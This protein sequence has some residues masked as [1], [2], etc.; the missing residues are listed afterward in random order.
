MFLLSGQ[1]SPTPLCC[2][3]VHQL[4]SITPCCRAQCSLWFTHALLWPWTCIAPLRQK[5]PVIAYGLRVS[6]QSDQHCEDHPGQ[7]TQPGTALIPCQGVPRS[8]SCHLVLFHANPGGL[9]GGA[10]QFLSVQRRV[11][12][13]FLLTERS[14]FYPRSGKL[15]RAPAAA[16]PRV[17]VIAW[18]VAGCNIISRVVDGEVAD[19]FWALKGRFSDGSPDLL[20]VSTDGLSM[21]IKHTKYC[22]YN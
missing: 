10:E 17:S 14:Y 5:A 4:C 22:K 6:S 13:A 3:C 16:L 2:W 9:A 11:N 21:W 1:R 12:P 18:A 15:G 7:K 19:G 20:Q 8:L